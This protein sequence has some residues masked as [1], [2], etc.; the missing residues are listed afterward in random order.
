MK[1][2]RR[3][4]RTVVPVP[5]LLVLAVL[6]V[7]TRR[8]VLTFNKD[9]INGVPFVAIS[10]KAYSGTNRYEWASTVSVVG[11]V[12]TTQ[13][14][15]A[16]PDATPSGLLYTTPPLAIVG[17]DGAAWASGLYPLTVI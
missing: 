15:I 10:L 2:W 9:V 3:A 4:A 11:H 16:I 14:G 6:T 17:R 1:V 12:V 5:P 13:Q 8:L 7:S